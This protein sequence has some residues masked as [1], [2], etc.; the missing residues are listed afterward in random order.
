MQ[1]D[2]EVRRGEWEARLADIKYMIHLFRKNPLVMTGTIISL[3][4]IIV[5]LLA[6]FIVDPRLATTEGYTGGSY[7][8]ER[9]YMWSANHPIVWGPDIAL[10]DGPEFFYLGTDGWGR[11]LL[12]MIILALPV[13][14][15]NA[16]IIV[17]VAA[18]LGTTLGALAGY[19]GGIFDEAVLRIT[20]VFFAFPGLVLALVFASMF[21]RSIETLQFA[22]IL[23]WWPPYVRLMRGQVLSEKEKPYVEALKA[24]GAGHLRVLFRHVMLNAIYPIL[25]QATMDLGGVILT[26]SAL[27]FLGF[28][29]S[30]SLP[31]LGNLAADG[32]NAIFSAPWV[33][34]FSGL[35]MLIISLAFNLVG[36]GLRDVLD[37]R[38]RR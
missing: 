7:P 13:D 37:P 12:S 23:V 11:D 33:I 6:N 16:F 9:K 24:L 3:F 32:Y 1:K 34:L 10:H 8:F 27:M 26:F 17:V 19:A 31:E 29:P 2:S 20:D 25:V 14:L 15:Y 35:T 5:A 21:G 38:L 18:L 30:K 4:F 22:I 28:S 36:D